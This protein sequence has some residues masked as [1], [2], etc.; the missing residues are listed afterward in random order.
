MVR[1]GNN[2]HKAKS[3]H[4]AKIGRFV[5]GGAARFESVMKAAENSDLLG[6][7]SARIGGRISP[8]LLNRQRSGP[9][10]RPILT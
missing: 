3:A 9:V 4:S 2:A 5:G 1:V 8:A 6:E 7:K 10:S